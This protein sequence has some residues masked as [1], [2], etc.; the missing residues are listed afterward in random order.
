MLRR[1]K[2]HTIEMTDLWQI[3]LIVDFRL[4][5][6]HKKP[7]WLHMSKFFFILFLL[8]FSFT[9]SSQTVDFTIQSSTGAFCTP[10]T[11]QFTQTCTGNPTGFAWDLG[12]GLK[13]FEPNPSTTYSTAGTYTI[14]LVAIFPQGT[15]QMSKTVT[16]NPIVNVSL[17]ADKYNTCRQGVINFSASGPSNI[18]TYNWDFGNGTKTSSPTNTISHNYLSF[19]NFNII[20][21]ATDAAGCS[22]SDTIKVDIKK[23]PI[24]V[25]ADTASGCIPISV[26][27]SA[28]A[29]LP[30]GSTLRDYSWDF[31]DGT[32][33]VATLTG[34]TTHLYNRTDTFRAK[35]VVVTTDGCNSSVDFPVAAFGDVPTNTIAY[36]VDTVLCGS[37]TPVF[38]G[39]ATNANSYKWEF[40]DG[41]TQIVKDTIAK[42]KYNSLGI[43]KVTVTPLFNNC[44]GTP[45]TFNIRIIGVIARNTF[46]NRCLDKRTFVFTNTSLGNKSTI[47]WDFGDG[48]PSVAT[49]NA[50]HSFPVSGRFITKLTIT[51]NVTGCLD[52]FSR[53]IY[54]AIPTLVNTDTSI[55][56]NTITR[57]TISDNYTN[58]TATYSWRAVGRQGNTNLVPRLN[59]TANMLGRFDT[60][61]VVIN[62]GSGFCRD[63]VSLDHP[64]TVKGP[65][66]DFDITGSSCFTD[67]TRIQNKSKPFI[68]GDSVISW[69]WNYGSAASDDD[70]YQPRPLVFNAAKTFQVT[71]TA[72]DVN[73][74]RDSLIKP[75]TINPLPFLQIQSKADT[76]CGGQF[77]TLVA[78][79]SDQVSW[80]PSAGLSC[81][82]C[83][84]VVV[85]PI[86]T[87]RYYATATNQ[88][89]CSISDSILL[90]VLPPFS[91]AAT[92]SNPAIC[93]GG[94][95]TLDVVP[96]GKQIV[97][98]PAAGL[99]NATVYNPV[100][101]PLQTTRYT[102]T[103]TDS[104]GCRYSS[105][106]NVTVFVNALPTVD[107]GPDKQ[108]TLGAPF[109]ITPNYSSNVRSYSWTPATLLNCTNCANPGGLATSSHTYTIKV[110][111]DS[112]CV[113]SDTITIIAKNPDP[114]ISMPKAFSPNNDNLNDY[115]YPITSGLAVIT[116]FSIYN[117]EGQV[118]YE[119]T[120]FSPG[121][122][123][124]YAW[125]GEHKGVKQ[126][127]RAYLYM[128]EAVSDLGKKVYKAGSFILV[129]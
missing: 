74:C 4:Y 38:V 47:T 87:T 108:I 96:K 97:W 107:A 125:N 128:L 24:I 83:D 52:T 17:S 53:T 36:P 70:S 9:A 59:V 104:S 90:T 3:G 54:T 7:N 77:D 73:G 105:I 109:S 19:G 43:K 31:G 100:V 116:R 71:L 44:A 98:A 99:S 78:F 115:Y 42:H 63:T 55:C 39:K 123:R 127:P 6:N 50:T 117:R 122:S 68:A 72:I 18:E 21:K 13:S 92:L 8:A 106:A 26:N 11:V 40:G 22:G 126:P 111:S 101:S 88:F 12:N 102:A 110:T 46:G 61:Y 67:S 1:M 29:T 103:L 65:Q 86:I 64:I 48:S 60:N 93:P 62:N 15:L 35:V 113:A 51:D 32:P 89:N 81:P 49:N 124:S 95:V 56:R 75:V 10:A 120:N 94:Q 16:V 80:S 45:A 118:L 114:V 20:V 119:R 85:Q 14:T 25:K 69:N 23:I 57:F 76:L 112:G 34:A 2:Y 27:F 121:S 58:P 5:R 30:P 28:L 79:H 84:T 33:A 41:T 66:L 129:R 82:N 91:A 37:E